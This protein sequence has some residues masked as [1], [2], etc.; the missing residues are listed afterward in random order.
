ME[1]VRK[2]EEKDRL[3]GGPDAAEDAEIERMLA[4]MSVEKKVGQ[5][6]C[7]AFRQ[8]QRQAAGGGVAIQ[9]AERENPL[10][11][12]TETDEEIRACLR[13]YHFGAVSLFR[14][15]CRDA[16]QTLRLTSEMQT[17]NREGGGVPLL[18]ATDQEG[19]A[20]TRL[21]FGTSG[22]GSMAL[23]ATG[24]S[25]NAEDMAAVYGE[26]LRLV[27]IHADYAPVLDVNNNPNNPAIGVRAF[28]D[29]PEMVAEYGAAFVR[30]LH[31]AGAA[32]TL[33]HFPG[34]GNTETDS[35][36]GLPRIGSSLAELRA[37]ELAPFR[38]AVAAGAD[39]IM[40]AHIQYPR[41][42]EETH[43]SRS[44]GE[45]ICLPATMS[46]RILT[47]LLREEMGFE[48]VIVTDALRM[49][50]I[51]D[52]FADEDVIRL[53]VGAGADL[54]MLPFAEDDESFRQMTEMTETAIRLVK[55]GEISLSRVEASARRM[56]RLKKRLGLL[57]RTDFA[58]TEEALQAAERGAHSAAH[59][60]LAEELAEKALTLLRNE[61]SAFPIRPRAGEK[62]L[63]LLAENCESRRGAAEMAKR[64]LAREG[65]VLAP[66][67]I[68]IMSC[69]GGRDD[70][71]LEAAE[72]AEHVIL[73]HR[74]WCA[75]CLDPGT[76]D[77][78]STAVFDRILAAR[79]AAG[80]TA[81]LV[82]CQL[83]YDAARFPEADALLLCYNSTILRELPPERGPESAFA[84]NLAVALC[85]CFGRG[86]PAG[87]L[88]VDVP[89]LDGA[90]RFTDRTL[91]RRG[92]P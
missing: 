33:K 26:E 16:A 54:L 12:V 15:N 37:C 47:E 82:S 7:A 19:G 77:G 6:M 73:V 55:A 80:R 74:A 89:A 84:P 71:C 1:T 14:E 31:R 35:H 28:S 46:R 45:K 3:R 62:T 39:M 90:W 44:T 48:G 58:A 2:S 34:H 68:E 10:T 61:G 75:A 81:I 17:A 92:T 40:T 88:P 65:V 72:R 52:H 11:A 8:R 30:G 56:L 87:R 27:G 23:A 42:E 63:I 50:A 67:D 57:S 21:S 85:A 69:G 78:A 86:R 4:G 25:A 5:M 13:K 60:R 38:A 76:E 66:E 53:T 20:I 83:P 32:A 22:P 51:A 29:D 18:I 24:D 43:V 70:Q 41:I 59:R 9:N 64:I 91:F 79:H 36:T 49:A